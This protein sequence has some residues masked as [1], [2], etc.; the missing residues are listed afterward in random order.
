MN[1]TKSFNKDKL[2]SGNEYDYI[3]RTSQNQGILQ[4]TG[5][6]NDSN[7]NNAKSWSLGL[8]QMDFFYRKR[9]W[10]AGQFVRKIDCKFQINENMAHFFTTILNHQKSKLLSVLVRDV[11]KIFNESIVKLPIDNSGI[12]LSFIGDF[13]SE[14]RRL[15]LSQ[16]KKYLADKKLDMNLTSDEAKALKDFKSGCIVW[17]DY[18]LGS[19]FEKIKTNKLSYKGSY[20]PKYKQGEFVLPALT[21]TTQNQGL[22]VYVPMVDTTILKNVISIASNGECPVFYQSK[23][24]TIFQDAYAIKYQVRVLNENES[25]FFVSSISKV[26]RKYNWDNKGSWEKVKNEYIVLPSKN[27]QIDFKFINDFASAILKTIS[28]EILKFI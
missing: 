25:L 9:K 3:T 11:D 27:K 20:L 10:Y 7:L 18:R 12:N 26:M 1:A 19:L 23:D 24:F 17:N 4:S 5:F 16:V 14:I 22:S 13:M 21:S 6:V 28:K 15:G 2:V 8:L